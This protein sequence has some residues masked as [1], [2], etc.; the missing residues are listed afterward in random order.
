MRK[1]LFILILLNVFCNTY[2]QKSEEDFNRMVN[3]LISN[4]VPVIQPSE[5]KD[6]IDRSEKLIILDARE[7]NEYKVSHIKNSIYAGYD[8]F[9][10]NCVSGVDKNA[11]IVV[12]CSVGYRSEKIAEK[13]KKMGYK[14]VYNLYGGIFKWINSGFPVVDAHQNETL[15]IHP[16]N[17]RWGKWLNKGIK[18]YE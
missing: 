15:N 16:Y 4:S 7:I 18:K 1:L 5:L 11:T 6:K 14:E 2:S 8:K 12:Y 3:R 13:I 10:K 17:E 9:N